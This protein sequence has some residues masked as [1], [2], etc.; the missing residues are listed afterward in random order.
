[1]KKIV[2]VLLLLT[3][4][5]GLLSGCKAKPEEDA[6]LS[7]QFI[8]DQGGG[9]ENKDDESPSDEQQ[10]PSQDQN[11]PSQDQEKPSQ[12]QEK[13][14]QDQEKPS[15]DQGDKKP[16]GDDPEK[17]KE[18]ATD[19]GNQE[20]G[21]EPAGPSPE[22]E[23]ANL[24]QSSTMNTAIGY[25]G[26][27][28]KNN[29][30]TVSKPIEVKAGDSLTFGPMASAQVTMGYIYDASGKPV[31]IINAHTAK[32][33]ETF[34][35]GMKLYTYSV[36][37]NAASV[38]FSVHN[39]SK[40][41]FVVAR[42]HEF[43]SL[44]YSQ[45]SGML[46]TFVEDPLKDKDGLFVGD[47]ICIATRDEKMSGLKGWARRIA[48]NYGMNA[49]NNGK[50][51]ISVSNKRSQGTVLTQLLE[52]KTQDFDYVVLHG[53]VNDAWS[54]VDVGVMEEGFDPAEFDPATFAGGLELLIYNAILHYG[55]TAS[56]GYLVNFKAPAC[57]KGTVKD[58]T[59]YNEV[60]M[61]I[62]DKWGITYFDMYNNE[63]LT[64][65]LKM[66]TLTNTT[67]YIHPS[68]SGYDIIS[69]YI[70][71]YMR[72]MTPVKQEILEKILTK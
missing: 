41:D 10:T 58:M 56:I 33:I 35:E 1:M 24:Y 37:K 19:P 32:E 22:E 44:E 61:K 71:D 4:C 30:F 14:S 5:I 40:N 46:A 72:T 50:S 43:N 26:K 66:D 54:L 17:P 34:S 25:D 36:P 16:S 49:V 70:A 68:S 42:N 59:A 47:S 51:G 18:E 29:N 20:N 45:L 12:D 67:D 63:E 28:D 69:P 38:K 39:K 27:N 6:A 3:M 65:E 31:Q 15:Q 11:K 9:Q 48:D 60:A 62:C 13:P 7:D 2:A 57:Q 52:K 53:G 55:D 23:L 64:K 8:E 21:E